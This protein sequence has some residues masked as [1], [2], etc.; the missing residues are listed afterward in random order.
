MKVVTDRDP[1]CVET[2]QSA[3][4]A[5]LPAAS[6][7]GSCCVVLVNWRRAD[8][9]LACIESLLR[10]SC[11]RFRVIVCDNASGDDSLAR[12][13]GWAKVQEPGIASRVV[14]W[15]GAD[16][17]ERQ[18]D[19]ACRVTWLASE[20]NLGFA[21]GANLGLRWGLVQ[22]SFSHFWLLNND[23][24]VD[25]DA[26]SALFAHLRRRPQVGI[27]GARLVYLDGKERIQAYGGA[28]FNRWTG[29]G[30]HLGHGEPFQAAHDPNGVERRMTYVCGASMFVS[31]RF[32]ELVGLLEERY[33][34]YFEE[35]DWARRAAGRFA[36]G[37]EPSAVIW[38]HEGA[39]I[40]SSSDAG[41]ASAVSDLVKCR[42]L[43]LFTRRFH[44]AALPSVWL[45]ALLRTVRLGMTGKTSLMWLQLQVLFGLSQWSPDEL[46]RRELVPKVAPETRE[47]ER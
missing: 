7:Q 47:A 2:G 32:I 34:L 3:S 39:T 42:S 43:M 10:S 16:P 23:S 12:F 9:T 8:L 18:T 29:R 21:G 28:H 1:T 45:V 33:F 30:R 15:P 44:P 17:M 27:C 36:M 46:V 14:T 25:P 19:A 13:L 40:G 4:E 5:L 22:R 37:Y 41:R 11:Q 31:R 24:I 26:L 6:G 20:R 35:L 38:H